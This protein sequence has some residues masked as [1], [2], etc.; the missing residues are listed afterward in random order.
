MKYDA[1]N[2]LEDIKEHV[3]QK[4]DMGIDRRGLL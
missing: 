4:K 2:R 3:I 1:N